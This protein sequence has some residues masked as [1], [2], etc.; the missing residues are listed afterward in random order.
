MKT[1]AKKPAKNTMIP[2]ASSGV[3]LCP[4]EVTK[5][6]A[7]STCLEIRIHGNSVTEYNRQAEKEKDAKKAKEKARPSVE[8]VA[9]DELFKFN[10]E[11]PSEAK[12]TVKVID[13]EESKVN[14]SF[15]NAYSPLSSVKEVLA[16]L[17]ALGVRDP[18]LYV[19]KKV[20]IGFET[21]E[22]YD[23]L[24]GSLKLDLYKDMMQAIQ[25]VAAAH[26][27]KSPF[28]STEVLTVKDNFHQDRWS[29]GNSGS[30]EERADAQA[31]LRETFKNTVSL[32]PV[33]Q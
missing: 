25:D 2:L 13:D 12:T 4:P 5:P 31:W 11:N 7:D 26:G 21:K 18:N 27:I 30:P 15:K 1:P 23:T 22:F 10:T 28:T 6:E 19:Q 32:T 16:K 29:I 8:L 9:L 33:A 17:Q 14:V 3:P 20:V 24:D